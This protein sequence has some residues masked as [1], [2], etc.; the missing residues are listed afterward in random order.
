[1]TEYHV[2]TPEPDEELV[3]DRLGDKNSE[4][5]P[6]LVDRRREGDWVVNA[7]SAVLKLDT[8]R[9]RPDQ[10][11]PLLVLRPSYAEAIAAVPSWS[12]VLPSIN[13]ID[14]KAK[15]LGYQLQ[16]ESHGDD[17]T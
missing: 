14:G 4:F 1:V 7:N 16:K 6:G 10:E 12:K 5:I 2:P 11:A 13:L 15:Q 9:L 3:D 17:A 8:P